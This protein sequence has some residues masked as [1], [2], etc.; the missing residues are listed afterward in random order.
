LLSKAGLGLVFLIELFSDSGHLRV[1]EVGE[2]DRPPAL[3]S[4][5]HGAEH[6]LQDGLLAKGVGNDLQAPALLNKEPLQ[7]VRRTDRAA[8]VAAFLWRDSNT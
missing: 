5:D 1:L 8:V 7:E 4:P 2:L 3:S 6:E